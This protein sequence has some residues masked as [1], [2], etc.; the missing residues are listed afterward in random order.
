MSILLIDKGNTRL[1]WQLRRSGIVEASGAEDKDVLLSAVF[2]GLKS[3]DVSGVYVASVA[4]E[5]FE[6]KLSAWAIEHA[7]PVPFFI[8]SVEEECGV[9]NGYDNP[10]QLGVDRWL[11]MIAAYNKF[12]ENLCIVDVGTAL[13]ID[14]VLKDGRHIGGLYCSRA[15]ATV[16][17][18]A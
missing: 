16:A 12:D 4:E 9:V 13:T 2:G 15:T 14:F 11:A 8:N 17:V 7:F 18:T 1:K 6:N 5:D 10:N 3:S